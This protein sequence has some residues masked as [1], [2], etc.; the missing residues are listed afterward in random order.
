VDWNFI[1][2]TIDVEWAH[3]EVLAHVRRLLDA[4][5]I[6]ATFFCTHAGVSVPGH[7]RALHPNFRHHGDT[8]RQFRES[9]GTRLEVLD[10]P[11]VY[12]Y[13]VKTTRTFCPEAK[14]VRSHSLFHDSQLFPIFARNGIE[15]D[16][17][18]LLPGAAGIRPTL[19]EHGI[20]E[21]PVYYMDYHDIM[22]QMTDFRTTSL[23]LGEPGL[24]VLSF[25][26]NLVYIN[27]ASE[28]DYA[29]T[30]PFYHDLERLQGARNPR[31]GVGSLFEAL[32]D[33]VADRNL[34][35]ATLG[36][37]NRAW[38]A[39]MYSDDRICHDVTALPCR[40]AFVSLPALER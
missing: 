33:E 30:K 38:W 16:S 22:V 1:C 24:K 27:A 7:E 36:E 39:S 35:V 6:S 37:V 31:R 9:T 26:P 40:N 5:G 28:N 4:R 13:V 23:K 25:H 34:A 8:L 32:L 2:F 15:Y 3:P 20:L 17:G 12:E 19:R 29:I 14:G 21:L 18:Y 10:E 11:T